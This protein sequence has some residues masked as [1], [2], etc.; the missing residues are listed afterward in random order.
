MAQ[1]YTGWARKFL[2]GMPSILKNQKASKRADVYSFAVVLWE[3]L[4]GQEP[5][6][7]M[8]PMSIAWLVME[9]ECLPIPEGVPE[10]F[11]TLLNQCFQTEPEDRPEFNYILKTIEDASQIR[12]METKV[13][14][15]HATHRTWNMEISSKYEEYKRRKEAISER[16]S[17]LKQR[18]QELH[19]LEASLAKFQKELEQPTT[20][21]PTDS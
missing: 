9:G 2:N 5:F 10:P 13:N 19:E 8:D 20:A 6:A 11:K 1:L 16:E 17:K 18:E 14:T 15:F 12:D 7:G 3:M 4:T 21:R